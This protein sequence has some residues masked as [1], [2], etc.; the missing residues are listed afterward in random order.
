[1][2]KTLFSNGI[3]LCYQDLGD[4]SKEAILLIAGLGEQLGE[5]PDNFCTLLAERGYRVIRYDNRDIGLSEKMSN[6]SY[7]LND[8]A[9]DAAGLLAALKIT[10]AHVVGMSMGGMIAQILAAEHPPLMASLCLIMTTSG[11]PGLPGPTPAVQE[12]MAR[13]TDGTVDGFIENWVEGK[14]RIDSPAYP[15]N[16]DA[17]YQRAKI[18]CDRSYHPGGYVRHLMAIGSNGSRVEFLEKINCPTLVLHGTDDPLIPKECGEDTARH[19]QTSR[20]ELINGM[21]HNL[22]QELHQHLCNSIIEHIRLTNQ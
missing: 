15:T 11:K 1:M 10:Q 6:Q 9:D 17:L 21:G 7:S 2:D 18:N 14:R 4:P 5:W 13:K 19:I 12:I 16:D 8:M 20:L 3:Q 22:P